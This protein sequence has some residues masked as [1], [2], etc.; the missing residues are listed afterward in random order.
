M[1]RCFLSLLGMLFFAKMAIAAEPSALPKEFNVTQHWVSL[2]VSFDIETVAQ[3]MGCVHRRLLSLRPQYD[4]YDHQGNLKAIARMRWFSF[5]P[6]FDVVNDKE[7]SLGRVEERIFTFF[8]TFD[9]IANDGRILAVATLNFWGTTYTLVEPQSGV[10]MATLHRSFFRLR[11]NWTVTILKPE[12]VDKINPELF[13]T[14][15]AFQTDLDS[16]RRDEIVAFSSSGSSIA[17]VNASEHSS[18]FEPSEEDFQKVM[19]LVESQVKERISTVKADEEI[20]SQFLSELDRLKTD[21]SFTE[22]EKEAAYILFTEKLSQLERS[23]SVDCVRSSYRG[24]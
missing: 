20:E 16:W 13:I 19:N 7:E 17:C 8:P 11:D 3:K 15:M 21:P 14:V 18:S 9:I 4:F 24:D 10:E 23:G 22:A 2:T 1:K 6:V 12:L 5:G